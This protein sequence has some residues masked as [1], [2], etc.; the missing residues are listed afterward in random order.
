LHRGGG[1]EAYYPYDYGFAEEFFS[2]LTPPTSWT[3]KYQG[4]GELT[5]GTRRSHAYLSDATH[6]VK[7]LAKEHRRVPTVTV[8]VVRWD[9]QSSTTREAV[10]VAQLLFDPTVKFGAS[11]LLNDHGGDILGCC[12]YERLYASATPPFEGWPMT[13]VLVVL[14]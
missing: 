14:S 6:A 8:T 2:H 12:D 4:A 5:W 9:R 13:E 7:V 11:S 3:G 1:P 10:A